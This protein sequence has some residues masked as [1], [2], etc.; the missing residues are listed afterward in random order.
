MNLD[1]N[2]E[3][4]MRFENEAQREYFEKWMS[5]MDEKFIE[6]NQKKASEEAKVNEVHI[7][8]KDYDS[9]I[10]CVYFNNIKA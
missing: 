4:L 10:T 3:I 9:D 2:T 5:K 7:E 6:D 1:A 8:L